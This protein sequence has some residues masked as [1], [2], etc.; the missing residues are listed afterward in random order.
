M[1][2]GLNDD[3]GLARLDLAWLLVAGCWLLLVGG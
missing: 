1:C 2:E 3:G